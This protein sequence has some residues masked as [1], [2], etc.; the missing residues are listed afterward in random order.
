M[1]TKTPKTFWNYRVIKDHDENGHMFYSIRGVHYDDYGKTI[2]GWDAEETRLIFGQ[3]DSISEF[4]NVVSE[5]AS[6]P[7]LAVIDDKMVESEPRAAEAV[8]S[9]YDWTDTLTPKDTT[10]NQKET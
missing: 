1:N 10:N 5:A 8:V 9:R 3:G 6:K 2:A 7:L 4:L